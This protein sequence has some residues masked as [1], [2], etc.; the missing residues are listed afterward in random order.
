[1]PSFLKT[2]KTPFSVSDLMPNNPAV[3]SFFTL[4]FDSLI[5]TFAIQRGTLV[6]VSGLKELFLHHTDSVQKLL[7]ITFPSYF[8]IF[9]TDCQQKI[10]ISYALLT[11]NILIIFD[12]VFGS[13]KYILFLIIPS[14]NTSRSFLSCFLNTTPC[15]RFPVSNTSVIYDFH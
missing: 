9:I 5:T 6:T 4:L 13:I 10:P 14:Y 11:N 3:S 1:M 7:T 15:L 12:L 2:H 8:R